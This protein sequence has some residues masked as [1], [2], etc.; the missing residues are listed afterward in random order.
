MVMSPY[1]S[2]IANGFCV[3]CLKKSCCP[4]VAACA[5]SSACVALTQ[6]WNG[7][8]ASNPGSPGVCEQQC[9]TANAG[10]KTAFLAVRSC[11]SNSCV[12]TY[13]GAGVEC[14]FSF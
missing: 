11:S 10:G 2:T 8:N 5:A 9:E 3:P 6:C 14:N 13:R 7:C 4:E 1:D 12:F